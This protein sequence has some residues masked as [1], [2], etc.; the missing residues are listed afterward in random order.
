MPDP[1]VQTRP[2]ST[3]SSRLSVLSVLRA[4]AALF[5]MLWPAVGATQAP[6]DEPTSLGTGSLTVT[7]E[8]GRRAAPTLETDGAAVN[9]DTQEDGLPT[10]YE[11][12]LAKCYANEIVREVTALGMQV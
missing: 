2:R 12:S 10:V 7:T 4:C 6:V 11:S 5:G 1:P 3:P 8:A 9:A